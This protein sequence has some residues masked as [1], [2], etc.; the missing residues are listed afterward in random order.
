[1]YRQIP[2]KHLESIVKLSTFHSIIMK[3][4]PKDVWEKAM[5]EAVLA[6]ELKED[7]LPTPKE[8]DELTE[9]F[10]VPLDKDSIN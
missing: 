1:M 4:I 6:G 8:F 3:H 2:L 9:F 5:T 10:N 7:S